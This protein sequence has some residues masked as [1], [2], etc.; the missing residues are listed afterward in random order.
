MLR[1]VVSNLNMTAKKHHNHELDI[2]ESIEPHYDIK[3]ILN[4]IPP[5]ELKLE[6]HKTLEK[7]PHSDMDIRHIIAH[8]VDG[9]R[10]DEFKMYF[11]PTL[12]TGFARVHGFPVGIVANN[13]VLFSASA[14]KGA[15]FIELCC[16]RKIPLLFLQNISGFMVGKEHEREE[17]N[18]VESIS[19][20]FS[21]VLRICDAKKKKKQKKQKGIAKHGA[22]LVNAVAC[23]KVPKITVLCGGSFG[24]GNYGMC[25]RAYS[26]Q[27]LYM[28]PNSRISVMGGAQAAYVLAEVNKKKAGSKE[29]EDFEK[30][31]QSQYEK[32]GHPYY[33]SARLWDDGIIDPRDTRKNVIYV[34]HYIFLFVKHL[35]Q[36]FDEMNSPLKK[37]RRG[38]TFDREEN[39]PKLSSAFFLFFNESQIHICT[40][41]K[42][43]SLHILSRI[44][45][46]ML[47]KHINYS[48]DGNKLVN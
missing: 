37:K 25:G 13:G 28:W 10:F 1:T 11:G 36:R 32:E 27:F 6:E 5:Q 44:F 3:N 23:A 33:S 22:K 17:I 31:I 39:L 16:Q 48:S 24:A 8:I 20:M 40:F 45:S 7:S 21:S 35:V 18:V 15:H 26:P 34:I 42:G 47:K 41:A 38:C 2:V 19:S 46:F 12:V 43:S 29:R 30:T 14:Q 4:Y 9:S